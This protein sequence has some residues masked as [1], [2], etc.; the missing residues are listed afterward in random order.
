[1][2]HHGEYATSTTTTTRDKGG[3]RSEREKKGEKKGIYL[4]HFWGGSECHSHVLATAPCQE[5]R[6][7][8]FFARAS[9]RN[10]GKRNK[11]NGRMVCVG[12]HIGSTGKELARQAAVGRGATK[13]DSAVFGRRSFQRDVSRCK[14]L[15]RGVTRCNMRLHVLAR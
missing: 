15:S 13:T 3:T 5:S 12:F 2:I 6:D 4:S 10:S 14:C 1:M 8:F 11:H 7:A 9:S